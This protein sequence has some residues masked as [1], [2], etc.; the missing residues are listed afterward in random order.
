M[1]IVAQHIVSGSSHKHAAW[2]L[3][4]NLTD[5]V[6]LELVKTFLGKVVLVEIIICQ[7]GEM[8]VEVALQ[9]SFLLIVLLEEFFGET[10]LLG[11]KIENLTVV[12]LA[13]ELICQQPCDDPA[14]ASDLPSDVYDQFLVHLLGFGLWS[15]S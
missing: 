9:K 13:V 6:A 10:A 1:G 2:I 11:R 3:I 7:K 12:E 4:G 15:A 14:T 5:G 8:N